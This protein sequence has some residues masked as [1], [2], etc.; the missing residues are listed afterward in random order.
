MNKM[1]L[2]AAIALS[3]VMAA[4]AQTGLVNSKVTDNISFGL[5][6]GAITPLVGHSFFENMRGVVGAELRKQVTPILGLGIE[7]EWGI[8]TLGNSNAFETQY[9]GVFGAVNLN[10]LF[11]GYAGTP[12]F[13][14]VETVLGAGWGHSYAP[15]SEYEDYNVFATKAGLNFN[16]NL[17][18]AKAW[19]IS[20][21][22]AVVWNM[23]AGENWQAASYYDARSAAFEITAGVTYHFGNS[24]GT[25]S[26]VTIS[27]CDQSQIDAL[28]A[29]VNDLR[30]KVESLSADNDKYKADNQRLASELQDCKNRPAEVVKEVEVSN[31]LSSVRYVFFKVGSSTITADQQPNVEMVASYLK[32]HPTAKVDIK[33]YASPEGSAEVNARL[34]TARAEAVKTALVNKY[35]IAADRISAEGQGVGNMFQEDSWN[36]VSIC[37]LE[38]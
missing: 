28:N 19:T 10:N 38:D 32:N 26:F 30:A 16:F 29:K 36:R 4:N 18:E 2:S 15:K 6:G 25:H 14:E 9:V 33:G 34:A 27:A 5:K 35:K 22:P 31:T 37:T 17:G 7:G 21:K 23:N 12:R 11:A 20:L 3:S 13:F 1:I 8:N 24:Y